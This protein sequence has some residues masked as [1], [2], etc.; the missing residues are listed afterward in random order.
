MLRSQ[1]WPRKERDA[2]IIDALGTVVSRG[3]HV[4][5]LWAGSEHAQGVSWFQR[6]KG[7]EITVHSQKTVV[8]M[9]ASSRRIASCWESVTSEYMVTLG[10]SLCVY[11][12]TVDIWVESNGK[13]QDSHTHTRIHNTYIK[14]K[15]LWLL[16]SQIPRFLQL[17]YGALNEGFSKGGFNMW[18]PVSV[19]VWSFSPNK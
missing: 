9:A 18:P 19:L 12:V 4:C 17:Y 15:C 3:M 6:K 8:H 11:T 14:T 5:A 10:H 13:T 2:Q 16:T 1:F 7:R